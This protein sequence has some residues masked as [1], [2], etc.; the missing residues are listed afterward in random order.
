MLAELETLKMPV[1][2]GMV[3]IVDDNSSEIRRM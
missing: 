2:S 3:F 1:E